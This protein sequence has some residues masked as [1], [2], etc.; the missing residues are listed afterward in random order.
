MCYPRELFKQLS[1]FKNNL[2][3][4]YKKWIV[5]GEFVFNYAS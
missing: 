3:V 2:N 5:F 4:Q 1:C